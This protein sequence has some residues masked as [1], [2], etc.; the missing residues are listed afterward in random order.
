MTDTMKS[1]K[2]PYIPELEKA[3]FAEMDRI[4]ETNAAKAYIDTVDWPDEYPYM[5]DASFSIA[6]SDTHIIIMY[7]VRGIDLRAK[8]ME[9]NGHVWEDSCCEFFVADPEDGTYYNFEMNCIGTLLAAKR[10]SREDSAFLP[11][12]KRAQ[13]IRHTSLE[14]KEY[15]ISGEIFCWQSAICIPFSIIGI[16]GRNLPAKIRANFYKC[17]DGSAH[18]HFVSWNPVRTPAPDFHRPEFF[19]ELEF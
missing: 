7:R 17:A 5:P 13:I 3:G 16:D 18:P 11:E 12:E 6:R 10:K 1:L 8:A 19:G 14:K 4:M 9:D 2:I 15:D